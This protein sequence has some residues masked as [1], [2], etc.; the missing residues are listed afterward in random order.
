MSKASERERATVDGQYGS[1]VAW[2]DVADAK[3]NIS[4]RGPHARKW[5]HI[6][7]EYINALPEPMGGEPITW[8]EDKRISSDGA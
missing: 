4:I 5:A 6:L 2:I 8:D 1:G 7:A 3:L